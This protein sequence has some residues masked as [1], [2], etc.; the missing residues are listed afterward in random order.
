MHV[1]LYFFKDLVIFH[2]S[3]S[4]ET[5]TKVLLSHRL[6]G[7]KL[8]P[9][10][11]LITIEI[12]LSFFLLIFTDFKHFLFNFESDLLLEGNYLRNQPFNSGSV[13]VKYSD[14]ALISFLVF[15]GVEFKQHS[16]QKIDL[17][18]F[19]EFFLMLGD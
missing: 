6:Q 1:L 4:L 13:L 5:I 9:H 3:F 12:R 11:C 7:L 2:L 17:F 10:S 19:S 15:S 14:V 8:L 18:L 16:E